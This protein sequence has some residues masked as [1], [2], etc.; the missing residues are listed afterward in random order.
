M[1]EDRQKRQ[2]SFKIHS[3]N[4]YVWPG[5]S[6]TVFKIIL[7][8]IL[9]KLKIYGIDIWGHQEWRLVALEW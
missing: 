6:K 3:Y 2:K 4:A 8:Q 9:R 7:A 1:A 5:I